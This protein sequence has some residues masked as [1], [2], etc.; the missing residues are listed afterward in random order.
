MM[1]LLG[2][3]STV[4]GPLLGTAVV[5]WLPELLGFSPAGERD[6][7]WRPVIAI[8]SGCCRWDRQN[9]WAKYGSLNKLIGGKQREKHAD[10]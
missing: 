10:A 3:A 5:I 8:I 7:P 4:I 9:D 2:S 1:I 6:R